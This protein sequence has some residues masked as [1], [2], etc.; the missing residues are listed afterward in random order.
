MTLENRPQRAGLTSPSKGLGP[1][2]SN[3]FLDLLVE[4][5]KSLGDRTRLKIVWHLSNQECSV[6]DLG[7]RLEMSQPAVSHHLRVLRQLKLVTIRKEG[8]TAHYR[9]DDEH[10]EML[11][12]EGT[13]HVEDILS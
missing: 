11:L 10:I 1:L 13:E 12:R 9:L 6:G 7:D 2:P 3:H 4:T 5:F 8:T